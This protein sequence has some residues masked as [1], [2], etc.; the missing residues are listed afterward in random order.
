MAGQEEQVVAAEGYITAVQPPNAFDVSEN[1]VLISPATG[2]GPRDLNS[3]GKALPSSIQVGAYVYVW[4]RLSSAGTTI[5]AETVHFRDEANRKLA[6]MGVID[7]V[8]SAAPPVFRADGYII[9]LTPKT[10]I[11][12][13]GD[14]KTMADVGTNTWMRYEGKRNAAGELVA[15]KVE[16]LPAR[17]TKFK[18]VKG[19]EVPSLTV[20]AADPTRGPGI[21][22][23]DDPGALQPN[24]Q[25]RWGALLH[26]H[27]VLADAAIQERV[28]RVGM[29]VVPQYQRDLPIDNPSRI[30]FNFYVIDDDKDR[31][32]L[33][34][35]DG[36]VLMPKGAMDRL[37]NDDQLAAVL[38]EGV[39]FSLQRQRARLVTDN[40]SLLSLTVAGDV[41]GAFVPGLSLVAA[42]GSAE[43]TKIM[44]ELAEQRGRVALAL[45]A[46]AGYD[47][48]QAPEA[49][50]L[51]APKELPA[52]R[53]TLMYTGHGG[54]QVGVLN[55]QYRKL[56]PA[57]GAGPAAPES[58]KTKE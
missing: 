37:E 24:D 28:R 14:V 43:A 1:H 21:I 40:R 25:V 20:K 52:D 30:R 49:W 45:M 33:C 12:F 36:L 23:L 39:T 17:A 18:A 10:Q 56:P 31:T 34:P 46:D 57:A 35:L 4:A 2:I 7:K 9:R 38:A 50:R 47:P 6:G 26:W 48:W 58:G 42:V 54:Y 29:S 15:S 27:T 44:I 41:A 13:Q 32:E 3:D 11:A 5:A 8:I 53:T 22:P 19:F 55:L 16:F 51:L